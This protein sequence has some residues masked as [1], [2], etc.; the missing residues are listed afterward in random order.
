MGREVKIIE[1][2]AGVTETVTN[3]NNMAPGVYCIVWSEG[4]RTLSRIIVVQ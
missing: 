4:L 1:P 2:A 3:V